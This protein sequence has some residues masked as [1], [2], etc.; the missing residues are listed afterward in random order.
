MNISELNLDFVN[1]FVSI[2]GI[3]IERKNETLKKGENI[4]ENL[5]IKLKDKLTK[6]EIKIEIP[7]EIVEAKIVKKG[8]L[9]IVKGIYLEDKILKNGEMKFKIQANLI[10]LIK[11]LTEEDLTLK[12]KEFKAPKRKKAEMVKDF[13][14]N[15]INDELIEEKELKIKICSQ[16]SVTI[17]ESEINEI[18]DLLNRENIIIR[19]KRGY[20]QIL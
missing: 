4:Q 7:K 2:G 15:L 17:S 14:Q 5:I 6:D 3:I 1:K 13:L 12:H 9:V 11:E 20:I 16:I 18:F 8:N 10:N 19:P